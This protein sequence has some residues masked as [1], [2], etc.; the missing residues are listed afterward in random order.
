MTAMARAGQGNAYYGST[1]EDLMDPF[2][3]EFDLLSALCARGLRLALACEPGVRVEIVNGYRTDAAGR[4]IL[5]DLAYGGEA[6]ALLRLTV[7]RSVA[8][9][10]DAEDLHLVTASLAF[11]DLDG[12]AAHSEPAHL[13]LPVV[14]AGAFAAMPVNE[15]V[16]SRI[17]E[18]NAAELQEQARSAAQRGDWSDVQRLLQ[19]LR[20][21]AVGSPWLSASVDELAAYAQRQERELFSKEA[22][23]NAGA[24]R[25]RLA[26]LD[27]QQAWSA[28]LEVAKASFLRRKLEQGRRFGAPKEHPDRS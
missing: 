11:A 13:R 17:A 3:Q 2:R 16:S 4:T 27:E 12:R 6:W 5:P 18:L 7:P 21:Q 10:D 19:E 8:E 15:L 26:A 9:A 20:A 14:S 22:L 23:Y 1:A 25:N 28:D 24:M